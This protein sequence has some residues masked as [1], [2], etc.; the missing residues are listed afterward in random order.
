MDKAF[1]IEYRGDHVHVE[2]GKSYT[3]EPDWQDELWDLLKS[4]CEGHDTSRVLAEGVLPAPNRPPASVVEA[5]RKAAVIPRLWLAFH[6]DNFV[7][8]ENTELYE[9]VA[10]SQGV[11]AKFFD[12]RDHALNWL[13]ANAPK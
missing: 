12:N 10:A 1:N 9:V 8:T 2:F 11:R 4:F 7:P 13:R 6:F 3:A 5:A